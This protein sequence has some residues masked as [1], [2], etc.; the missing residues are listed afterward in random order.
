MTGGGL[1][2]P[3]FRTV[4]WLLLAASAKRAAGRRSRQRQLLRQRTGKTTT[5]WA[6]L[7]FV[8]AILFM[9]ALNIGAAFVVQG[10]VSASERVAAEQQGWVVVETWF[11]QRVNDAERHAAG[12]ASPWIGIDRALFRNYRAEGARIAQQYGGNASAIAYHLRTV[13]WNGQSHILIDIARAA[14]GLPAL[15]LAGKLPRMFGSIVLLWW[16]ILLVFQGEG[17]ELDIQ[18]RRHPMWEWLFSHP[19]PAGAVFLAEMLS[20]IAANPIYWSAPFFAGLL[21]AFVYGPMEGAAAAFL[22]GIPVML[23][24]ACLGKALEIGAI[25]RF[26]VRSRGAMI[27]LMSWLGYVSMVLLAVCGLTISKIVTALAGMLEPLTAL[28]WPFLGLFLGLRADGSFSFPLGVLACWCVALITIAASVRYSVWGAQQGL[29]GN[30]GRSDAAPKVRGSAAQFG[31]N[32]LY[33]KEVLWFARDRSAIVQ[34]ILIPLTIAAFQLFNLRGALVAAQGAWNYLCGAGIIFG[35]YFLMVLGPKSLASEGTAL[36]LAL[37]WPHGLED[38]L[39][40][41][42]WLWSLIAT[43][44]VAPVLLYAAVLYPASAWKVALVGLAW[45]LFAR[46]MA[47]KMVTLATVTTESGEVQKV[48]TGRRYAAQLGMLT[49]SIGVLTQ[50]WQLAVMGIVYSLMTAAAMWQNFRARLPYLY[51]PWSEKLPPPPTLMHAMV[52]ISILVEAGAVVAGIVLAFAGRETVAVAHAVIYG[53]CAAAV[54]LGLV[55]FLRARGVRQTYIWNW[56]NRDE[57]QRAL[58]P[59]LRW[60]ASGPMDFCLSLLAGGALGLLLGLFGLG[61]LALLKQVPAIAETLLQSRAHMATIP[62]LRPSMFVM[63]VCIAPFAEEFLFRGML[64]RAL[65]REWGGWRAVFGSAAFFAVY[66]PALSWLPVGLLGAT[67]ALLFRKTGRLAPA[68]VL[69]MVYNTVVLSQ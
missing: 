42:S 19:V 24:A 5:N 16:G 23:A 37:T 66:H 7:G 26:S 12:Q 34:A 22:V 18:R 62:Y 38:L 41:K 45:A 43:A 53:L 47:E 6:G 9:A 31:K 63:A 27:G 3:R 39:K 52:A 46:S 29:S 64:Y 20:P 69:H 67:N 32:A 49:F 28:P 8:M 48:P 50:Q 1:G 15:G 59:W 33:R 54:S 60:E 21:Y 51:D 68:V 14:P 10:A 36:W 56:P 61:Y 57:G 11:L 44:I 30:L 2:A 55:Q 17:L 58:L 35:T 4:V 40:A 13:V 25:L 65:D